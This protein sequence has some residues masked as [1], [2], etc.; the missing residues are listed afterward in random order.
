MAV[1][2]GHGAPGAVRLGGDGAAHGAAAVGQ[3]RDRA[4][5]PDEPV[6]VEDWRSHRQVVQVARAHTRVVCDDAVALP[7]FLLGNS[8]KDVLP[9]R[10]LDADQGR[11]A[12]RILSL[13]LLSRP[14]LAG[15]PCAVLGADPLVHGVEPLKP[16]AL[17]DPALD[18]RL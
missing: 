4:G 16:F 15:A 2:F 18:V 3:L 1:S 12:H 11:Y 10:R 8:S 13:R 7:P 17:R 14:V 6:G 5:E 9:R